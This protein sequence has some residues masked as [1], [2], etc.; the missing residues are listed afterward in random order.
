MATVRKSPRYVLSIVESAAL[1]IA[2]LAPQQIV[3]GQ[4]L[5]TAVSY[6]QGQPVTP[7]SNLNSVAINFW[8]QMSAGSERAGSIQVGGVRLDAIVT[9][10]HDTANDEFDLTFDGSSVTGLTGTETIYFELSVSQP[11]PGDL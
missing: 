3:E 10:S 4:S 11:D 9:V 1:T 5:A 7:E 8:S 2:M 6:V